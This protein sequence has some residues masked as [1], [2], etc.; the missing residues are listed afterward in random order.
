MRTSVT[1]SRGVLDVFWPVKLH[2]RFEVTTVSVEGAP[3][4]P[5]YGQTA[6]AW[7]R[8]APR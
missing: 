6:V 1:L 3:A 8:P 7:I 2:E 5:D 4:D